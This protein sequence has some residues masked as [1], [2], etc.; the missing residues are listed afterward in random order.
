[1][2]TPASNGP[3][4][5]YPLIPMGTYKAKPVEHA[6]TETKKGKPQ[7]AVRFQILDTHEAGK[8]VSW[9]GGFE[10]DGLRYTTKALE[11]MGWD[12]KL[13]IAQFE[14]KNDVQIVVEHA[15]LPAT[16]D[17]PARTIARVKY[18]NNLDGSGQN[19]LAKSALSP[20]KK[21]SAGD[22]IMAR[23]AAG[24][25]ATGE[26]DASGGNAD[27]NKFTPVVDEC[28]IPF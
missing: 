7:F 16:P 11:T 27:E 20:E 26:S 18:I 1:M 12:K 13:H 19:V 17:K 4:K 14:P 21:K 15:S 22:Q 3:K 8:H 6:M 10:G 25:G 9:W 23:L 24:E 2:E 28:E 5:D